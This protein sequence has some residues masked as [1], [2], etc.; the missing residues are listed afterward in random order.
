LVAPKNAAR[1]EIAVLGA[2]D[3]MVAEI[4]ARPLFTSSRMPAAMPA[5]EEEIIE[6][7]QPP[8]LQARLAG[9]TLGPDTREALFQREGE[10]VIPIKIGGEID[11]WKVAAIQ[12]D[13]VVLTSEF[14]KRI[15][16]PTD[17]VP[18]GSSEGEEDVPLPSVAQANTP[19]VP[20]Y[21]DLPGNAPVP[22]NRRLPD[23]K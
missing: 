11:G 8:E 21:E 6:E 12:L 5:A 13:H 19:P 17:A 10:Q 1:A 15:I 9:I 20:G 14:G 3:P 16:K 18:V 7:K 2:I 22:P 23:R 4:L